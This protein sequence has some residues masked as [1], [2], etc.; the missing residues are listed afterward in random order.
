[1]DDV[2]R[3]ASPVATRAANASAIGDVQDLEARTAPS[4]IQAR[5]AVLQRRVV[6]GVQI[7]D[8]HDRARPAARRRLA[9]VRADEARRSR[10]EDGHRPTALIRPGSLSAA[11][12]TG[13]AGLRGR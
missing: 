3:A 6:V 12:P 2:V 9:E 13:R 11:R 5:R 7:I 4:P 1:M 8:P 10:D